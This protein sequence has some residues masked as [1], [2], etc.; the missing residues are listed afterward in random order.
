MKIIKEIADGLDD[1]HRIIKIGY[2]EKIAHR[3][4]L[5]LGHIPESEMPYLYS[6]CDLFVH[7]S[8]YEG[9][10]L[11]CLEAMSCGCPVISSNATSLPEVVNDAGYLLPPTDV[12]QFLNTIN[13]LLSS[14]TLYSLW[15]PLT[16][17]TLNYIQ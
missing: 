12:A 14:N 13:T 17:N 2:G 8:L 5:S 10:G 3:K 9:F 7:P 6:A 16:I 4:I 15:K 11:P 1:N